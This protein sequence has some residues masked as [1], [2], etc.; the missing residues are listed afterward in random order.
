MNAK[1]LAEKLNQ[2][3]EVAG[4]EIIVNEAHQQI[5]IYAFHKTADF[6]ACKAAL[7]ALGFSCG[8][9]MGFW[10]GEVEAPKSF[11]DAYENMTPE[12]KAI[13]E[14]RWESMLRSN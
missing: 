4:A 2:M 8:P 6:K 13:A 14:K 7:E 11:F 3:S 12:E 1:E 9:N 10:Q 5:E